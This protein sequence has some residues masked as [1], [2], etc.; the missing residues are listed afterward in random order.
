M[1]HLYIFF[2]FCFLN[3][4]FIL[5]YYNGKSLK[6]IKIVLKANFVRDIVTTTKVGYDDETFHHQMSLFRHQ[7][8]MVTEPHL[9]PKSYHKNFRYQ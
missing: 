1:S 7:R 8:Y 5:F 3:V 2:Y 6:D 4:T 9:T